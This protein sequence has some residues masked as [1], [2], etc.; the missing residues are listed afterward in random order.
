MGFIIELI[1]K[2]S[3]VF[4]VAYNPRQMAKPKKNEPSIANRLFLRKI[5]SINFTDSVGLKRFYQEK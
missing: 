2:T 4:I 3:P 5:S 1:P